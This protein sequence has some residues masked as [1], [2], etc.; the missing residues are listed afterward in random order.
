MESKDFYNLGKRDAVAEFLMVLRMNDM[1]FKKTLEQVIE[2][3]EKIDPQN[4]HL[5][6]VKEHFESV[7]KNKT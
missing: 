5:K 6:W 1:D 3:Y 4:P 2:I 7:D